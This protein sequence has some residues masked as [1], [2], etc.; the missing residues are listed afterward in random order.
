MIKTLDHKSGVTGNLKNITII[1]MNL[2]SLFH[3]KYSLTDKQELYKLIENGIKTGQV[4]PLPTTVYST[5]E[6]LLEAFE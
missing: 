6:S 5:D 4:Q 1:K 2:K 3:G